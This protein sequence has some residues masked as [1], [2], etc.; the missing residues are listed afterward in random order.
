MSTPS[1]RGRAGLFCPLLA[2]TLSIAV[3]LLIVLVVLHPIYLTSQGSISATTRT[4][5]TT[6]VSIIATLVTGFISSQI[7]A[8][9]ARGFDRRMSSWDPKIPIAS[10]TRRWRAILRISRL[11]DVPYNVPVFVGYLVV[12]LITATIVTILAPYPATRSIPYIQRLPN[13]P[14]VYPGDKL[15][16]CT[17]TIP[18]SITKYPDWW[19]YMWDYGPNGTVYLVQMAEGGCPTRDAQMLLGNIN[20]LDPD[21]FAYADSGV[22]VH[23]SSIGAPLRAY[24]PDP[25]L[26]PDFNGLL[27]HYG[28]NVVETT[29]CVRVMKKNP[30]RCVPGGRV[31]FQQPWF[32]ITSIDGTCTEWRSYNSYLWNHYLA[33][34]TMAKGFCPHGQVGQG[35]I[36]FG[37]HGGYAH[38]L[39]MSINDFK[40]AP[41]TGNNAS[42]YVITCTVDARDV[43]DY[44]MVSLTMKNGGESVKS[45]YT[46]SLNATGEP[47]S[48]PPVDLSFVATAAAANWQIL[49]QNEGLD[50]WFDLTYQ[51]A[52]I[53]RPPPYAFPDSKNALE[54]V[55]GMVAAMVTAR[56][57]S[58]FLY[59]VP[60][61]VRVSNLR[62]GSGRLANLAFLVPPI[63]AALILAT[64]IL[65]NWFSRAAKYDTT[66]LA[67]LVQFGFLHGERAGMKYDPGRETTRGK[68]E[69]ATSLYRQTLVPGSL[70]LQRTLE[71]SWKLLVNLED[72]GL[73]KS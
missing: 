25:R 31:D 12:G 68:G 27:S 14:S 42:T 62:V 63:V 67:D 56:I 26:G 29:Q 65:R 9:L 30:I 47:C 71:G 58:T 1:P 48:G 6:G 66:N 8:L 4:I 3:A 32:N 5:Y 22:A 2:L 55:L 70:S 72:E 64:L 53:N 61:N 43:F 59:P 13:G 15:G 10:L 54:D 7:Q 49:L 38:W 24:S 35:T 52:G 40:R 46:R 36:I 39:A 45:R 20:G 18:K 16:L 60:S 41:P 11:K 33:E 23:R 50:G 73:A 69:E 28:D 44:R 51:A 17:E 57:N 37:A 21:T 19:P 34:G